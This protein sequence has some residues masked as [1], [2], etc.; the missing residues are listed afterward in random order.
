[1]SDPL[2]NARALARLLDTAGRV[3]GTNVRFGLDPI[4]G[5]VPGLGDV[6]G[7]ALTGYIVLVG[8]R[9]GVPRAAIVQMVLNVGVDA[10]VG[11]V[12]VLGDI[13][14]VAWKSN[15]RN[16]A[17]IE[18]HVAQPAAAARS[19]RLVVAGAL[20]ALSLF[21]VGGVLLAYWVVRWLVGLF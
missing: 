21:V 14:D 2:K 6:A 5:L 9:L 17:L 15:T 8:A 16:L 20:A 1:M 10:L 11:A 19:S 7:A 3:P 12:P 18:R 4:L 13:F